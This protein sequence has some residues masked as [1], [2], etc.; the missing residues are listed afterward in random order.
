VLYAKKI[1]PL[2]RF[3]SVAEKFVAQNLI[4]TELLKKVNDFYGTQNLLTSFTIHRQFF[5]P[6]V[7]R[8]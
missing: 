8:I 7:G 1:S 2:T 6:K 3:S 5:L 4:V